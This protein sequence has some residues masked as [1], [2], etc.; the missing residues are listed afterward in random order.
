MVSTTARKMYMTGQAG[1]SREVCGHSAKFA[2]ENGL[3][4]EA[5]LCKQALIKL[6]HQPPSYLALIHNQ[7]M[8]RFNNTNLLCYLSNSEINQPNFALAAHPINWLRACIDW[9]IPAS[10]VV[11]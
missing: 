10:D 6:I 4:R 7:Y 1:S 3:D 11:S 8:L 5:G 2:A 9:K